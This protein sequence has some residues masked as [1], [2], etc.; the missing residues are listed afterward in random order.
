MKVIL[1]MAQTMNGII[2]REDYGEDFLSD[3]NWKV[4]L[5]LTK[6]TGCF[7][8]GRKTYEEVKKW[9][10]YNFDNIKA[11]KIIISNKSNFNL[12]EGYLLAN[13]PRDALRKASELGFKKVILTGGGK[14]N[15]AFMKER[16]VDEIIVNI[17]PFVLGKGIKIFSEEDFENKLNLI[18]TKVL[19]SG[20]VQIHYKIIK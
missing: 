19:K 4:F 10:N 13:S 11:T 18:D 16:L 3:E 17:E 8:V 12:G 7:I 14:I 20:I 15:T 9:K 6:E 1:Y 5:A 2:A